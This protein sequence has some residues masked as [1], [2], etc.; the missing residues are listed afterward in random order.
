VIEGSP[1]TICRRCGVAY[2]QVV[3]GTCLECERSDWELCKIINQENYIFT[4][5]QDKKTLPNG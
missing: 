2:S 5:T 3:M 4:Q 1:I